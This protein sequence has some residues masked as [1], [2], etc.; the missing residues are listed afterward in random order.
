MSIIGCT[1]DSQ[2]RAQAWYD[3]RHTKCYSLKLNLKTD[4]DII[5]SNVDMTIFVVRAG[6]LERNMLPQIDKYYTDRKYN[7]ISLLLNGTEGSGRYGYK[8]GYKYGYRYGSNGAY[9]SDGKEG[10]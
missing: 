3:A 5:G 7:N 8:Y 2:L 9:G 1:S 10:E 6:L 4:A